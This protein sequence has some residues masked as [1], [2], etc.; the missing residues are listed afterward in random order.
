MDWLLRRMRSSFEH[1]IP[2]YGRLEVCPE[3]S[4]R[5]LEMVIR[6]GE[7]LMGLGPPFHER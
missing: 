4:W 1:C 7:G 3:G 5:V 6:Y 2:G